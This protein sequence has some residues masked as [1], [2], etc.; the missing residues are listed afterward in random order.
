MPGKNLRPLAGKSLITWSIEQAR[1]SGLLD[2]IAVSSD[3]PDI[4]AVAREAGADLLV[5]RPAEMATDSSSKLPAIRHAALAAEGAL[6]KTASI[7]VDLQPTSP[8]REPT[9]IVAAVALQADTGADS[10]IT[11]QHAKCSPYFSLVEQAADGTVFVSKTLGRPILR[12]QDAPACFDMNGSIYVWK[13]D[14]F[15]ESP[16][17]FYPSTRIY[18]MP[19]DRSVDIDTETDFLLAGLLMERKLALSVQ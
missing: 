18:V 8:L 19:E 2:I 7:I 5:D 3:A 14:V 13:R 16:A 4:L 12:R 1:A 6:G 15:I 10:V 17:V 9:D 11:G